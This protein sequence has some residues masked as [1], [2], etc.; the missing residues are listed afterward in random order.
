MCLMVKSPHCERRSRAIVEISPAWRFPFRTGS[1]L[2]TMYASPIVS[3]C[4]KERNNSRLFVILFVLHQ[5]LIT[6]LNIFPRRQNKYV[7]KQSSLFLLR[8]LTLNA[9]LLISACFFCVCLFCFVLSSDSFLSL[10]RNKLKLMFVAV[11]TP[12]KTRCTVPKTKVFPT[13]NCIV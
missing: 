6:Y 7:V 12:S 11:T 9:C 5:S 4:R 3:T 8:S 1:P 13:Y 2:Q 10:Q